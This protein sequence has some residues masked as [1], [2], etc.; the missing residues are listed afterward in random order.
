MENKEISII[1]HYDGV[2][3]PIK[4]KALDS[5]S[6]VLNNYPENRP[7][8]FLHKNNVLMGAFTFAFYGIT[9]NAHIYVVTSP[10]KESPPL[11]SEPK[12]IPIKNLPDKEMFKKI[13]QKLRLE[14]DEDE[15]F[16]TVYKRY[17]D[18]RFA[19][20]TAKMKDRFFQRVEGTIKCHRKLIKHFFQ[21]NNCCFAFHEHQNKKPKEKDE[22]K[23]TKK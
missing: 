18:P 16:E 15:P 20:E 19:R 23:E 10:A 21:S 7:S 5:I 11:Q 6:S 1:L 8:Y 12:K 13:I 17:I 2:E 4:V 9:D 22:E 3:T 14:D